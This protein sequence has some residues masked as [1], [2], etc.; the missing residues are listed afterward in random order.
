MHLN[1]CMEKRK[2]IFDIL[3]NLIRGW[4]VTDYFIYDTR[5]DFVRKKISATSVC[6]LGISSNILLT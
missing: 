2:D 6:F 4:S 1:V 5:K 3:C